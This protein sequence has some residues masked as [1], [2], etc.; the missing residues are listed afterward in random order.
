MD[1]PDGRSS[2]FPMTVGAIDLLASR[3]LVQVEVSRHG[4]YRTTLYD[5]YNVTSRPPYYQC[6]H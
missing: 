2:L 3:A 5:P 1:Y 4:Q 6:Q